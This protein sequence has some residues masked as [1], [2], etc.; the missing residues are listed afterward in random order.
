MVAIAVGT[1]VRVC[2]STLSPHRNGQEGVV[3]IGTQGG[4]TAVIQ[5]D[6]DDRELAF[7]LDELEVI[8]DDWQPASA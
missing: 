5:L 6:D 7:F 1:R 4:E 2:N 8:D 3:T